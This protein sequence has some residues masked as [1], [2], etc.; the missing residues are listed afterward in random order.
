MYY[1]SNSSEPR[2]QR[3]IPTRQQVLSI[4][5]HFRGGLIVNSPTY[6]LM[7]WYPP[8]LSWCDVAT[9]S[10]VY[11]QMREAGDTHVIIE[12]PNG[13]PLY[14]ESDQFYS[15]DK[16]P[17]LDWTNGETKLDG[18]L[19][20]FVDE[21]IENG[22]YYIIAMDERQDHSAKIMQLVL[23]SLTDYQLSFGALMPGYDGVFYGWSPTQVSSWASIARS[24]KPNCY[25]V[26]EFNVGHIP[27][28]N[29]PADFLVGGAMDGFDGVLGEFQ[30][31]AGLHSDTTWQIV[32][33]L[34]KPYNRP[35]D[36]QPNDDPHPPFYL[37]D[38]P[39]GFRV[40]VFFET[41]YPYLWVRI[42]MNDE[43]ARISAQAMIEQERAYAKSLGCQFVG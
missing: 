11:E 18:N 14:D 1:Y 42:D 15:S 17:A 30:S 10:L 22:F 6:G 25:L 32:G 2:P 4:N 23:Q 9:R 19:A 41:D 21:V 39:R 40:F 38:S 35:S 37:T 28:G 20:Q 3:P 43:G 31:G 16:F 8:A 7:P 34:I 12:I 13:L 36:Q 26:I 24:I 27:V 33:R 5:M 29:G